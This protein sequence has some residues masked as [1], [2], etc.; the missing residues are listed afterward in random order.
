MFIRFF[1]V[2]IKLDP[3][4]N[5]VVA[6]PNFCVLEVWFIGES[7]HRP[8]QKSRLTSHTQSRATPWCPKHGKDMVYVG[9]VLEQ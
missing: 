2:I 8:K 6:I 7:P 3:C 4:Q 5:R 1:N 9:D